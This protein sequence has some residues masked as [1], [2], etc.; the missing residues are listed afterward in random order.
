MCTNEYSLSIAK[1]WPIP[2]KNCPS[3]G[4][5]YLYKPDILFIQEI[6]LQGQIASNLLSSFQPGWDFLATDTTGKSGGLIT[7]WRSKDIQVQ[8]SWGDP[9]CSCHLY[10]DNC[11]P[12]PLPL[13]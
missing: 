12:F 13:C 2:P 1:G 7:G 3:P 4:F 10:Q 9:L 8:N 6:M 11:V 5:V